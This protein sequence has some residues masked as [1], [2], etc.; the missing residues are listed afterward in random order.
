MALNRFIVFWTYL[1]NPFM[2]EG[3]QL[4]QFLLSL[5]ASFFNSTK[6]LFK[7][8]DL[9]LLLRIHPK[10]VY[11]MLVDKLGLVFEPTF[12][13]IHATFVAFFNLR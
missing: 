10:K 3:I 11:K 13:P 1:N 8:R 2:S 7:L 9:L 4:L 6:A 5:Q 12:W